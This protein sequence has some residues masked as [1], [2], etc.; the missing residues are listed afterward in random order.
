MSSAMP[1]RTTR[2]RTLRAALRRRLGAR[3]AL[4]RV[5]AQQGSFLVEALISAVILV[6]VG[7]GVL[8][9]LDRGNQ[10]GAEQ[11]VQA[12]AGNVAHAEQ[13][14]IRA[15]PVS[16]QSNMRRVSTRA[17]GGVTY[18]VSSRA[19]WLNDTSGDA[20]CTT[21]GSSADYMKLSTVVT[22]PAM[23][24]RKP[25]TLESLITPGVRAFDAAQ[26]SLAVKISDRDGN[27]VRGLQ[28]GLSG[29]ATLSDATSSAGCVL[30]GYLPADKGYELG[31]SRPPDYVLWDG[32][33]VARVA[34]AVSGDHTSNVALQFDR[35][36]YLQTTFKTRKRSQGPGF[37][38]TPQ[39]VHFTNAD[40]G[41][42][43]IPSTFS[44]DHATS[45]LLFPFTSAYTIHPDSCPA[46]EVPAGGDPTTGPPAATSAT[47]TPGTTTSAVSWL[48]ALNVKVT[49][50]GES[51]DRAAV[52]VTTPCGT[53]YHRTTTSDG[54]IDD[55]GVPYA[56]SVGICV[57]DG[58]RQVLTTSANV[59]VV[60][61]LTINI[62]STAPKG[63]CA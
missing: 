30:W 58:A 42:V 7:L 18:Q 16:E 9:T 62:P 47:V 34:V 6:I 46:A 56:P 3:A 52:R 33:Q 32:S 1:R 57:S 8:K 13:E 61:S 21:A 51:V 17:V 40:G 24:T 2:E 44:G 60:T 41:G 23:G 31:F 36:G 5:A 45:P 15:L 55:P 11:R 28:L 27:P 29:G 10:L 38:T 63:T 19:D 53:I 59:K 25:V 37:A 54:L 22:W 4:R 12:V 14:Q 35:G 26:G 20:S 49:S 43:N 50:G 39:A 48:P